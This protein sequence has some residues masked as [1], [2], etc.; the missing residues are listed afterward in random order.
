MHIKEKK[1]KRKEKRRKRGKGGKTEEEER[2]EKEE[3]RKRKRE[4][5]KRRKKTRRPPD[6]CLPYLD[7]KLQH[8]PYKDT[9][10]FAFL[11]TGDKY[12]RHAD[13]PIFGFDFSKWIFGKSKLLRL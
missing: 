4:E 9:T 13:P 11:N 2:E 10:S 12:L 3:E 8:V 1:K 6:A 7:T 5:K